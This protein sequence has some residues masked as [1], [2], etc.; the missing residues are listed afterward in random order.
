M[1]NPV[2]NETKVITAQF[3]KADL[4]DPAKL[5]LLIRGCA[6]E[7]IASARDITG[8]IS[9]A[10]RA[11]LVDFMSADPTLRRQIERYLEKA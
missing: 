1:L 9:D 11:S 10:Q 4:R 7:L 2:V 6:D 8:P 3:R 5:E